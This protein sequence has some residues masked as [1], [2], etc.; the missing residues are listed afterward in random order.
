MHQTHSPLDLLGPLVI[1]AP[2]PST[3]DVKAVRDAALETLNAALAA[4][5]AEGRVLLVDEPPATAIAALTEEAAA[6]L[7]VVGTHGRTGLF[8]MALGSVAEAVV[9]R[10]SCSVLVA[11]PL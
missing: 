9:R 10:S 2:K 4:H 11:R 6:S 5:G 8:R 3:E 7:V 1:S